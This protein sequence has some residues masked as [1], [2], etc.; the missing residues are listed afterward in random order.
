MKTKIKLWWDLKI[1]FFLSVK[2]ENMYKVI[3][4]INELCS[5]N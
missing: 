2:I 4:I 3:T 5:I 1:D